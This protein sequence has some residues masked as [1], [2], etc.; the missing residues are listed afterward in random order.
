MSAATVNNAYGCTIL[1]YTEGQTYLASL[2]QNKPFYQEI[3]NILYQKPPGLYTC[4]D[5]KINTIQERLD[6]GG[7]FGPLVTALQSKNGAIKKEASH[8]FEE[9]IGKPPSGNEETDTGLITDFAAKL[10]KSTS[11]EKEKFN[12]M[13]AYL[14]GQLE[15]ALQ[16]ASK[17]EKFEVADQFKELKEELSEYKQKF[18]ALF[19]ELHQGTVDQS[20]SSYQQIANTIRADVQNSKNVVMGMTVSGNSNTVH[21]GDTNT[22]EKQYNN[23]PGTK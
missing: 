20:G 16:N 18:E 1:T 23:G 6:G 15:T 21:I 19:K 10:D 13:I 22:V 3:S 2:D 8:F 12:K 7:L 9:V 4:Q 14:G 17:V 5:L 11:P